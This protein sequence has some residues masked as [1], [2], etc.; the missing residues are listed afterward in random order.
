[1][2][3]YILKKPITIC[4]VVITFLLGFLIGFDINKDFWLY[5]ETKMT[6]STVRYVLFIIF[7]YI[8]CIILKDLNRSMIVFRNHSILSFFRKTILEE[9]K[10]I[11][12]F[13]FVFFSPIFLFNLNVLKSDWFTICLL[14]LNFGMILYLLI[15]MIRLIDI[16]INKRFLS[17][18]IGFVIFLTLDFVLEEM[19]FKSST[20]T[21]PIILADIFV[22]PL[23]LPLNL[24]IPLF[25]LF[26]FTSVM[27]TFIFIF[28]LSKKDYL[29]KNEEAIQ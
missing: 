4:F 28:K 25:I 19:I 17:S 7:L 8:D 20:L 1:M 16:R 3:K 22:L 23:K 2:I 21:N 27:L 6:I 24:Y 5:F 18:A 10:L 29:L 15:S 14:F 13:A 9:I 26:F 12:L 11:I